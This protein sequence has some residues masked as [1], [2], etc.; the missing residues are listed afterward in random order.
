MT[1]DWPSTSE[2]TIVSRSACS[3]AF[4]RTTI[5]RSSRLTRNRFGSWACAASEPPWEATRQATVQSSVVG[6]RLAVMRSLAGF[7]QRQ[8]RVETKSFGFEADRLEIVDEFETRVRVVHDRLRELQ[9]RLQQRVLRV[10]LLERRDAAGVE[11]VGRRRDALRGEIHGDR[12]DPVAIERALDVAQGTAHVG[13]DLV[14]ALLAVAYG[15][16]EADQCVAIGVALGELVER[17]VE[18]EAGRPVHARPVEVE[19]AARLRG[20]V[21]RGAEVE[22][23]RQ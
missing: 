4:S 16:V 8:G 18:L 12:L 9:L 5:G 23:H 15:H 2:R 17:E 3:S 11:Q 21:E 20:H 19:A 10:E 13:G 1:V 14:F 7:R 6:S 22:R